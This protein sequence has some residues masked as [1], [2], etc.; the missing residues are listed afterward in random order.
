MVIYQALTRIWG[1]GKFSGVG[2]VAFSH[3]KRLGVTHIWFTGIPRHSEGKDYVKGDWGSPYSIVDYYDVNPYLADNEEKR[4]DEFKSLIAR[5]KS[6]G[7]KVLIDFIPNHVSPDY[8]DAHGGIST[9]GYCDFD[10]SDTR[11]IDYSRKENWVAMKEILRFWCGLGVDGFRCDM[12]ELV[13]VG[14]FG[15]LISEIKEEFPDTLFIGEAYSK[16]NYKTF[17]NLGKFD[18]LYDKS[19]LYDTLRAVVTGR[20]GAE[21]ITSNWQSLGDIQGRMLNFLENHDEQRLPFWSGAAGPAWCAIAVSTLFYDCPFMLYFGQ[22]FGE[23]ASDSDNGRTSIFNHTRRIGFK[24]GTA[25]ERIV[26]KRYEDIL[27]LKVKLEG[28]NNYDLQ[29]CQSSENG[30]DSGKHFSFL[31]YNGVETRLFVCN[32][33]GESA[34]LKV[35]IPKEAPVAV[36]GASVEIEIPAWDFT[37]RELS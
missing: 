31:R 35:L 20:C 15:Y 18:I 24:P 26:L 3:L 1:N 9:T 36:A 10:W 37:S 33:S 34:R 25:G 32:F 28:T 30:Y 27:S 22:E 17:L 14:F 5:C 4:L 12:V 11:K 13:P 21:G 23:G 16:E 7:F 19:G 6:A 2:D 29:Y 8:R